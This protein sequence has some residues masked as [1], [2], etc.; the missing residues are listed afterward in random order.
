[1]WQKVLFRVALWLL[2]QAWFRMLLIKVVTSAVEKTETDI[3]DKIVQFLIEHRRSLMTIANKELVKASSPVDE[4]L[5]DAMKSLPTK[6]KSKTSV[7][8]ES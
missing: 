7:Q 3:D 2:S 5:V 8:T 1:M 4:R 6:T